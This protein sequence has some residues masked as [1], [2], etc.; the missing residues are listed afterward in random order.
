MKREWHR[1]IDHTWTLF[2]DRDGVIN[3]K[4]PGD[5]VKL[6]DEFE[7]LPGVLEALE[8]AAAIFDVIVVVT[9][10]QGIGK[11]IMTDTHLFT[12]HQHMIKEV[13]NNGGRIDKIY[14][15]P[16]LEI[17]NPSHRKPR[18]GMAYDARED[19]PSIEFTKSIII[20][21]SPSDME[22]GHR[23][24]MK[25]VGIG[26]GAKAEETYPSLFHF[27]DVITSK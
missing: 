2:L 23:L 12:I 27:I 11:G 6:I 19:F 26:S 8:K 16:D 20:G 10:Q 5:Y 24:G 25:C 3:A 4:L 9:N 15:C 7:F 14:F 22:F 21:D 17:E 13:F 18:T 1:E